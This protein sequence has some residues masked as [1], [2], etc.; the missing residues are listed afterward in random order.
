MSLGED[1]E[2]DNYW[3]YK[4]FDISKGSNTFKGMM[5]KYI[6][7]LT[8]GHLQQLLTLY[9]N[10]WW[11]RDRNIEGTRTCVENSTVIIGIVDKSNNLIGFTRVL[12]DGVYKAIIFDVIVD[13]KYRGKNL[14]QS[15][16]M[17]VK[18]HELLKNVQ[19]FELYCL[20][21]MVPFYEAHGFTT[22]IGDIQL[23]K[24]VCG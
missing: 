18:D 19:Q 13:P 20:P 12:S 8:E 23:M 2:Y 17:K 14:G 6:S 16:I 7:E 5:M 9:Q 1:D 11:S 15:L 4:S 3:R 21:V 22:D 10:E 24:C